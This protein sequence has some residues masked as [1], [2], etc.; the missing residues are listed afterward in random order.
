MSINAMAD[1]AISRRPDYPPLN[2]LPRT[3]T[4]RA[5]ASSSDSTP[6]NSLTTAIKTLTTYIPTETLTL[7]VAFIAVIQPANG[8]L[9]STLTIRWVAFLLF[10]LFTPFAV[11]ITYATKMVSDKKL[12]PLN[13]SYWPWWEM[14]AGTIAYISWAYGLPNSVFAQFSWYS[15][16]LAGFFVLVTSTLLGMLAGLFQ[17]PLKATGNTVPQ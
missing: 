16:P 10:L 3:I 9:S 13:P 8:D 17:Q 1:A 11:W 2:D 5:Q 4:E 12:M 6:A 15:A 14:S 7:Y